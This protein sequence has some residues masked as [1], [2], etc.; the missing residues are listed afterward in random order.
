MTRFLWALSGG[1]LL[2][3]SVTGPR[4]FP[5]NVVSVVKAPGQPQRVCLRLSALG[6]TA[7][8]PLA[9]GLFDDAEN[10]VQQ[11]PVFA[12]IHATRPTADTVHVAAR[13]VQ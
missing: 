12:L 11:C 6:G 13:Q 7:D 1:Q 2:R 8:K 10:H 9:S 5:Q 4:R 3:Q